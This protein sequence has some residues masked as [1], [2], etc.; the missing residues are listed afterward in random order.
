MSPTLDRPLTVQSMSEL[1]TKY[2]LR[3][4][5]QDR[6]GVMAQ[7]TRVLGD[8]GVSLASVI[9]KEAPAGVGPAEIV[10]TTHTARESAVQEAVGRLAALDVVDEVCNLVRVEDGAP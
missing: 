9:Q 4:R 3:L 10:I 6:P 1:D 8:L 7:I 5:A 2:Y